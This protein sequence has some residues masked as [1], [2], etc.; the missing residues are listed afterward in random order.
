MC[1]NKQF[2][3]QQKHIERICNFCSGLADD[4]SA[5]LICRVVKRPRDLQARLPAPLRDSVSPIPKWANSVALYPPALKTASPW[6]AR[7]ASSRIAT[8]PTPRKRAEAL[9]NSSTIWRDPKSTRSKWSLLSTRMSAARSA[10]C[11]DANAATSSTRLD[12]VRSGGHS[13]AICTS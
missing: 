1:L 13:A 10:V 7:P 2:M 6:A 3:K 9:R 11:E 8:S 5:L 4:Q 12:L